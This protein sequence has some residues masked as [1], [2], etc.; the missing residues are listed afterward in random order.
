MQ[1]I[2]PHFRS[3]PLQS[4]KRL[5]F[6]AFAEICRLVYQNKHRSRV[7]LERIIELAFE[8]NPAGKRRYKKDELLRLIGKVK[9]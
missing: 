2:I 7:G 1:V 9:E 5:D 4:S 6:E 8:M 3:Y